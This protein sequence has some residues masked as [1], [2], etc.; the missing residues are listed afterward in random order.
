[1]PGSTYLSNSA[2]VLDLSLQWEVAPQLQ[3][4]A[5]VFNLLDKQYYRW[6]R[7]RFINQSPGAVLGGVLGNGIE[8]FSEPGRYARVG[9]AYTF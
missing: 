2:A 3:L 6:E 1:V 8:R 9:L 4:T 7:I 5:G